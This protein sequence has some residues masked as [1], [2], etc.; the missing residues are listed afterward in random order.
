MGSTIAPP[1]VVVVNNSITTYSMKDIHNHSNNQSDND[2]NFKKGIQQISV[3][4]TSKSSTVPTFQHT[5]RRLSLQSSSSSLLS[6]TTKSSFQLNQSLQTTHPSTQYQ[7]HHHQHSDVNVN[8][9][10]V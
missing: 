3:K 1:S 7:Y 10:F 6:T 5:Q 2:N 8:L 4:N 9:K